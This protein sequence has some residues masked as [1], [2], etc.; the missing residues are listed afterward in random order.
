MKL[1]IAQQ[2]LV[3][4]II[5]KI[6][7]CTN[8]ISN[9][10]LQKLKNTLLTYDFLKLPTFKT[11]K[12]IDLNCDIRLKNKIYSIL[13]TIEKNLLDYGF[14]KEEDY[15]TAKIVQIANYDL[16]SID[17]VKKYF[18]KYN[19]K[20]CLLKKFPN[21]EKIIA[22][23]K[24]KKIFSN[25]IKFYESESKKFRFFVINDE[26]ISNFYPLSDLVRTLQHQ[27][28]NGFNLEAL[29]V[30]GFIKVNK[31]D[32]TFEIINHDESLKKLEIIIDALYIIFGNKLLDDYYYCPV[33]KDIISKFD[34][35]RR[36][37]DG[38]YICDVCKTEK[39]DKK[40]INFDDVKSK[41]I[42]VK[43]FTENMLKN[44]AASM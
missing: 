43:K 24:R 33:C 4:A 18:K 1:V 14:V 36:R 38:I 26:F 10:D 31:T 37:H 19:P 28:D 35:K 44:L 12:K 7:T 13:K 22:D 20:S 5:K 17:I 27:Y 15:Y 41:Y 34:I 21:L 42:A 39:V 11:F 2:V 8:D 40:T 25:L 30:E 6:N 16:D 23:K 9:E 3:D 29:Y 32:D